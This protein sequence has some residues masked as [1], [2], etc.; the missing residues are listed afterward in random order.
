MDMNDGRMKDYLTEER[1]CESRELNQ[2]MYVWM[3]WMRSSDWSVSG[4]INFL[5]R[6]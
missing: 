5:D 3:A 4:S 2:E 6:P 1:V